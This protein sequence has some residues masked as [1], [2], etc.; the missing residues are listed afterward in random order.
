MSSKARLRRDILARVRALSAVSADLFS[1]QIEQRIIG[2]EVFREAVTLLAFSSLPSE[3]STDSVI[4]TARSQAQPVA[5]PR[6][7]GER[8]VFCHVGGAEDVVRGAFG[9]REPLPSC[10]QIDP[11]AGP[12][13]C[14]VPG[15]AFDCEGGRLG[16]GRG[17][18]DRFLAETRSP[19]W[20]DVFF[21]GICFDAQIVEEVPC[22]RWDAAVDAVVTERRICGPGSARLKAFGST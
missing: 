7:E 12:F 15:V 14:L 1:R 13:L 17:F 21:A 6:C 4:A 8:I 20:S 5:L 9:V 22:E 18:Y 16:R 11:A 3:V 2:S 19:G 10:P